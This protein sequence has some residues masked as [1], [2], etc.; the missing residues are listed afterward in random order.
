MPLNDWKEHE[1][2]I[3]Y[4]SPRGRLRG[5][6]SASNP[7]SIKMLQGLACVSAAHLS[8]L[9]R[10]NHNII[11]HMRELS[12]PHSVAGKN[13]ALRG[14]QLSPSR[15]CYFL[16]KPQPFFLVLGRHRWG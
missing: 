1:G 4:W 16:Q 12:G 2:T 11:L 13:K 14:S 6:L 3:H 8:L 7:V 5:R 10:P 9:R 15:N